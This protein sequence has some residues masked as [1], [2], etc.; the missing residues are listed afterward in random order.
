MV[1]SIAAYFVLAPLF[2]FVGGW[3]VSHFSE[4]ICDY[5][6]VTTFEG[7]QAY[8]YAF[9]VW[10][11]TIFGSFVFALVISVFVLLL[12]R[13]FASQLDS[14]RVRRKLSRRTNEN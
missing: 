4:E 14:G 6:E 12:G 7:G 8:F 10:P 1:L 9:T 11:L 3:L 13:K 5:F 2:V